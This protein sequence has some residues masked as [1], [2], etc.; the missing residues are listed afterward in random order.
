MITM[1]LHLNGSPYLIEN[2]EITLDLIS[3]VSHNKSDPLQI[4][5]FIVTNNISYI[6]YNIHVKF[7]Q[8][9]L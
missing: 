7:I 2:Y 8:G 4:C 1:I 6:I 3:L 9:V 5:D